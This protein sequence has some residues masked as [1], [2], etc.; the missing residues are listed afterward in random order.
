MSLLEPSKAEWGREMKFNLG[1]LTVSSTAFEHGGRI[2][3]AYSGNGAGT[4]PPLSWDGVPEGTTSFA[5]VVHDFDVPIIDGFTHWVLYGIP[6][7]LRELPEGGGADFIQG[8]NGMGQAG[9]IT[10]A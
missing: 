6:G 4:S 3:D 1:T 9:W 5:I 10:A 8:A 7:D 2:P